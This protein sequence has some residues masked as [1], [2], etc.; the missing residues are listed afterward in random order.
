[1]EFSK[2]WF[3]GIVSFM[4][5]SV[6][7]N[8]RFISHGTRQ[9]PSGTNPT[10][11]LDPFPV[12]EGSFVSSGYGALNTFNHGIKSL[13]LSGPNPAE[14]PDP[15]PPVKKS[16]VPKDNVGSNHVIKR[17]VPTGPN[18]AQSPD[19]VP[20]AKETSSVNV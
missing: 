17:R 20:P 1:M 14:S 3:L 11:S 18:P 8:C 6:A 16:I 5:L 15:V 13:V 10:K 4:S 9:V 12:M 19:P 7:A 2:F